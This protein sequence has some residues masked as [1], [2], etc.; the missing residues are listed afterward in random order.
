[1]QIHGWTVEV[2]EHVRG[3]ATPK[4][5]VILSKKD[6]FVIVRSARGVS[7]DVLIQRG[8][9]EALRK[10]LANAKRKEDIPLIRQQ[11]NR[12]IIEERVM[13]MDRN[14]IPEGEEIVEA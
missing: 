9:I 12:A 14:P 11:L 4:Q 8:V 7:Q 10:D 5:Q 3:N 2:G 1:M 13:M 6:D